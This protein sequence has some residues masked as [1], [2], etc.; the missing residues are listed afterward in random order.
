MKSFLNTGFSQD[1]MSS[2]YFLF[3]GS[4][5]AVRP[6]FLLNKKAPIGTPF[7]K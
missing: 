5:P 6:V 3:H 1:V 2:D 7:G 4:I